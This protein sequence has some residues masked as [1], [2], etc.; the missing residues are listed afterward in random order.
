M[1]IELLPYRSLRQQPCV[2]ESN[3]L[4]WKYTDS[5]SET[6]HELRRLIGKYFGNENPSE[7]SFSKRT[8]DRKSLDLCRIGHACPRSVAHETLNEKNQKITKTDQPYSCIVKLRSCRQRSTYPICTIHNR[9][10]TSFRV[11]NKLGVKSKNTRK[12]N[13]PRNRQLANNTS[14]CV[15][16]LG[17]AGPSWLIVCS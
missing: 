9:L 6:T 13:I 14:K 2:Y 3:Q 8:T 7:S 11:I 17:I 10:R 5:D 15:V 12:M 1:P 4:T 16:L